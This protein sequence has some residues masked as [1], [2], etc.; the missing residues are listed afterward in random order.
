MSKQSEAKESQGYREKPTNC[1][2]CKHLEFKMDLPAW[3]RGLNAEARIEGR[4]EPYGDHYKEAQNFRCGVGDFAVKKTA[5]CKFW[6]A[7][8]E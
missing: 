2:N 8:S 7:K 3:M 1:S 6:E 5:T 4:R